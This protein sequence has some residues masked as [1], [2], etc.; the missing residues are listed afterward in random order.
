MSLE[1]I[2]VV[3]VTV[4]LAGAGWT[5]RREILYHITEY[6]VATLKRALLEVVEIV[7]TGIQ[8]PEFEKSMSKSATSTIKLA[9][10]V[11]TRALC[12]HSIALFFFFFFENTNEVS[13]FS[14]FLHLDSRCL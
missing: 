13:F 2:V 3:L 11:C 14:W 8:T 10:R 4:G 5:F 6:I 1:F 9:I 12:V 7:L